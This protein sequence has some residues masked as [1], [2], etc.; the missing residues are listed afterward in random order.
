MY[1]A[2]TLMIFYWDTTKN[3]ETISLFLNFMITL[4]AGEFQGWTARSSTVQD[5]TR[6]MSKALDVD[7]EEEEEVAPLR[8]FFWAI[9]I[10]RLRYKEDSNH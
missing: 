9:L 2:E 8:R 10:P 4:E 7:N 5:M 3:I 6:A 1:I